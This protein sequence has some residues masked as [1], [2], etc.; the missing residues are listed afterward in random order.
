MGGW[1]CR[2]LQREWS[3][4]H[5]EADTCFQCLNTLREKALT[6]LLPSSSPQRASPLL[7]LSTSFIKKCCEWWAEKQNCNSL[8]DK[9]CW[10]MSTWLTN[11]HIVNKYS[12]QFWIF[13]SLHHI[14]EWKERVVKT[15]S[16]EL[17]LEILSKKYMLL[18]LICL[19]LETGSFMSNIPCILYILYLL[20]NGA[21]VCV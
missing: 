19:M 11:G 4:L 2:D 12:I 15:I 8:G 20:Q 13:L 18:F 21:C 17:V 16:L 7:S 10:Q 9:P 14:C 1:K 6:P 5:G 3:S